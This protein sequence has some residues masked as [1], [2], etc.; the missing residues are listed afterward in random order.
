MQKLVYTQ[1]FSNFIEETYRLST[2]MGVTEKPKEIIDLSSAEAQKSQIGFFR[3][4]LEVMLQ[5]SFRRLK[6]E[7]N[8]MIDHMVLKLYNVSFSPLFNCSLAR[9]IQH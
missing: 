3:V 1:S 6:K 2:K 9:E 5:H 7:Q 8:K 4:N